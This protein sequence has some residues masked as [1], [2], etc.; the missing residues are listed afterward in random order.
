MTKIDV[1]CILAVRYYEDDPDMIA[2]SGAMSMTD[3]EILRGF[4][5]FL[6]ASATITPNPRQDN[7]R[8]FAVT[9][10]VESDVTNIDVIKATIR[11]WSAVIERL[12]CGRDSG[13]DCDIRS[14]TI[15]GRSHS[16]YG[17]DEEA[18]PQIT[19]FLD[20]D[21]TLTWYEIENVAAAE[22]EGKLAGHAFGAFYALAIPADRGLLQSLGGNE[23]EVHRSA[24]SRGFSLRTPDGI[25]LATTLV[26][27]DPNQSVWFG[28]DGSVPVCGPRMSNAL[29]DR[30]AELKA[31]ADKLG[32]DTSRYARSG[33]D[34]PLR[35]IRN[36]PTS[37]PGGSRKRLP[38]TA[39]E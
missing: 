3:D 9:F 25:P 20:I 11:N 38:L 1:E 2:Q 10:T 4:A 34:S 7:D 23:A 35:D 30:P 8:G 13:A 15:D 28:P 19:R 21:D 37:S 16:M 26:G 27:T 29:I 24:P 22:E 36:L 32:F 12:D 6:P 31:L 33:S 18:T 5:K 39:S 17:S 14:L